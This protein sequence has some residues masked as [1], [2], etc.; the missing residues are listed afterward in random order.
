VAAEASKGG[1][2]DRPQKYQV[3]VFLSITFSRFIYDVHISTNGAT[4]FACDLYE[5]LTPDKL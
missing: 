1:E 5:V 3:I 4:V 2:N